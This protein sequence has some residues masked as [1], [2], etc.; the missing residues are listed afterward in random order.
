M[1][2][3][4]AAFAGQNAAHRGASGGSIG[5]SISMLLVVY[6]ANNWKV[7]IALQQLLMHLIDPLIQANRARQA[8]ASSRL[9]L[10]QMQK[11]RQARLDRLKA[12]TSMPDE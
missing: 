1:G 5:F 8:A 10:S 9:Q 6:L 3:D 4:P 7:V 2:I 11:A 12:K